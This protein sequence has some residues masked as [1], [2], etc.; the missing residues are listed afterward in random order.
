SRHARHR[1][2]NTG[3]NLRKKRPKKRNRSTG[4]RRAHGRRRVGYAYPG[5]VG[6]KRNQSGPSHSG[7]AGFGSGFY[8]R[9][10]IAAAG[11]PMGAFIRYNLL[12]VWV[13]PDIA[14]YSGGRFG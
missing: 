4:S 8:R 9:R 11:C 7:G 5:G 2:T 10:I 6:N 13:Y 1:T 3:A 12:P 14:A